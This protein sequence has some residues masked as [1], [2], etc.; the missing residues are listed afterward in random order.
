M[1]FTIFISNCPETDPE[2]THIFLHIGDAMSSILFALQLSLRKPWVE[3]MV[4]S[5]VETK[6]PT[7][8]EYQVCACL[9]NQKVATC[10]N[11]DKIEVT[12][13]TYKQYK[14]FI[15]SGVFLNSLIQGGVMPAEHKEICLK[16]YRHIYRYC[17]KLNTV[18]NN[19][20]KYSPTII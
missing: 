15:R 18:K 9:N 1:Y 11:T 12:F 14:S 6:K 17:S 3:A 4:K 19:F 8:F 7:S 16:I 10:L 2:G 20:Q 5:N 13:N